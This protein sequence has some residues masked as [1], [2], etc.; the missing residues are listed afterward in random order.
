VCFCFFFF[1]SF[2]FFFFSFFFFFFVFFFSL[3]GPSAYASGSTSALWLTV[4]SPYWTFPTFST[5]SALPRH[6][7]IEIWSCNPVILDVSNFRR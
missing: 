1:F 7:G 4:L 5:S 6:L 2:F 3:W